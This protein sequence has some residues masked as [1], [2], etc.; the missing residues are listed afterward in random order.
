MIERENVSCLAAI[1][2]GHKLV[3][4]A[5]KT[6][7]AVR[8]YDQIIGFASEPIPAGAHVHPHNCLMGAFERDYAFGAGA[9][10]IAFVPPS[11]RATF[12]GIVRADG[13]IATRN[14]VAVMTTVNC[15]APSRA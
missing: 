3:T 2:A 1:P 12:D 4:R 9:R 8:K 7:E 14:Y 10:P 5:I 11:E 15:S 13:R 6:G